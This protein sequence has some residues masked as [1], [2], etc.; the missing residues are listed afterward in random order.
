M[1]KTR[2]SELKIIAACIVSSECLEYIAERV[3]PEMFLDVDC[4]NT[5]EVISK[6]YSEGFVNL[7]MEMVIAKGDYQ[8]GIVDT[9]SS[10]R[11]LQD[12]AKDEL[13]VSINAIKKQYSVKRLKAAYEKS[14]LAIEGGE[15]PFEEIPSLKSNI[16]YIMDECT[17]DDGID[18]SDATGLVIEEV[19]IGS[20]NGCI[21]MPYPCIERYL[22]VK[23]PDLVII[24]ARPG[25][26]KTTFALC[27][28]EYLRLH[29]YL[30]AFVSIEMSASQLAMKIALSTTD[31]ES[32]RL[33]EGLSSSKIRAGEVNQEQLDAIKDIQAT[34]KDSKGKL[35]IYGNNS[36][37][38][39][40]TNVRRLAR[41]GFRIIFIDYL[42]LLS[43]GGRH[44]SRTDEVDLISR[45]LKSEAKN[46]NVSIIA[47]SQLNRESVKAGARPELHHLKQS[48][49]IEQDADSVIFLY[50]ERE[51][52]DDSISE[53]KTYFHIAKNRHGAVSMSGN[54]PSLTFFKTQSR[55]VDT[56]NEVS[57]N[58]PA[59]LTPLNTILGKG[60]AMAYTSKSD[61]EK[62]YDDIPF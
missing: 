13:F 8:D 28:A 45:T 38:N 22:H 23:P 42:Q 50:G 52:E 43:A 39:L 3:S 12:F 49:S 41:L 17:T 25:L 2:L 54:D 24:G 51:S 10:L 27:W 31:S 11:L 32:N 20:D 6:L 53:S 55:F 40:V 30:V 14:L 34:Q 4:M 58:V 44:S 56:S 59:A 46:N 60:K 21:N 16:E 35:L 9:V 61:E 26:G 1:S 5:F 48:G 36:L 37:S 62:P 33:L 57:Y 15:D 47:L 19:K 18:L 7:D 29:G